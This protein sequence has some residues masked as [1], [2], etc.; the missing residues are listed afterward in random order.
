MATVIAAELLYARDNRYAA[1]QK[2]ARAH[3][4]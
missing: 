2:P 3:L 4:A 1:E